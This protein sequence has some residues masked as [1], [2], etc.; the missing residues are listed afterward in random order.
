MLC[1]VFHI[2]VPRKE[3]YD[4]CGKVDDHA[5]VSGST[6]RAQSNIDTVQHNQDEPEALVSPLDAGNRHSSSN[7]ADSP[8]NKHW[9]KINP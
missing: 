7:H 1:T 2:A 9:M 6:T 3:H 4:F 5:L 8:K